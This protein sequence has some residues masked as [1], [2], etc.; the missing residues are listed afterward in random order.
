V[1]RY[2]LAFL[3][4]LGSSQIAFAQCEDALINARANLDR[5]NVERIPSHLYDCI[6]QL[7]K[8]DQVEAIQAPEFKLFVYG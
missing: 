1:G 5:G 8:A 2:F 4:F 7:N 3:F 6:K